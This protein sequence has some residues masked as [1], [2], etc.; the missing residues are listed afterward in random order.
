M[1][2]LQAGVPEKGQVPALSLKGELAFCV[3]T[4]TT[5]LRAQAQKALWTSPSSLGVGCVWG[6]GRQDSRDTLFFR[7][8][9]SF[10]ILVCSILFVNEMAEG[11]S[12]QFY[13]GFLNLEIFSFL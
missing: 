5:H 8:P 9:G 12:F 2:I 11:K 4:A 10:F 3:H 7:K 13:T 6:V 1:E